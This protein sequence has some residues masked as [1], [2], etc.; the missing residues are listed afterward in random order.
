MQHR[1]LRVFTALDSCPSGCKTRVLHTV[2][3]CPQ[4]S[5]ILFEYWREIKNMATKHINQGCEKLKCS[6]SEKRCVLKKKWLYEKS[7]ITGVMTDKKC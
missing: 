1:C 6:D 4:P 3:D 2:C 5:S 7:A